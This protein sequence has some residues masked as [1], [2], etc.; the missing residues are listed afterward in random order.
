MDLLVFAH[1]KEAL[2]FLNNNGFADKIFQ[3][4]GIYQN[5]QGFLLITGQGLENASH[6][7]ESFL[8]NNSGIKRIINMGTAGCLSSKIK[9]DEIYSVRKV[10]APEIS[11]IQFQSASSDSKFDCVSV[12]QPISSHV[13]K[14]LEPS[15]ALVDMELWSIAHIADTYK[16]PFFSYKIVSDVA[17]E[18]VDREKIIK[19]AQFYSKKLWDYYRK[20]INNDLV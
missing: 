9:T 17:S 15:V 3:M 10:L 2:A 18:Q 20:Y 4:K 8:K 6:K 7:I 19:K 12:K 11:S 14:K 1:K 16:I 5:K 13:L